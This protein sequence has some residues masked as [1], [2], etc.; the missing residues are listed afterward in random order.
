MGM[1]EL[2]KRNLYPILGTILSI[3]IGVGAQMILPSTP[4]NG[5]SI[6]IL[7]IAVVAIIWGLSLQRTRLK[8]G[9]RSK[10]IFYLGIGFIVAGCVF[11]ATQLDFRMEAQQAVKTTVSCCILGNTYQIVAANQGTDTDTVI[12]TLGTDG[13]ITNIQALMGASL[14]AI[15]TGG[16][17]A[18]V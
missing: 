4:H 14:P 7:T 6:I 8:K 10:M 12:V 9:G 3:G 5:I 11:I 13:P 16:I 2:F 15:I 18:K 1:R 17:D